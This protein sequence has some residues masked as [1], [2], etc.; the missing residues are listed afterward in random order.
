MTSIFSPTL[1]VTSIFAHHPSGLDFPP[2]ASRLFCKVGTLAG[3]MYCR[4]VRGNFVTASRIAHAV[5]KAKWKG[6]TKR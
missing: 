3:S 6:P 2:P 1:P 5:I 4:F